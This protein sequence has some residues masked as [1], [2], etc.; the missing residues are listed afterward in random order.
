MDFSGGFHGFRAA[1]RFGFAR[2]SCR[3]SR[4][5]SAT[6]LRSSVA[7]QVAAAHGVFGAEWKAGDFQLV[8]VV[9]ELVTHLKEV[10]YT[11]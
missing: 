6:W 5:S 3:W 10:K 4:L 7:A 2:G 9:D 8:T 11:V 1:S